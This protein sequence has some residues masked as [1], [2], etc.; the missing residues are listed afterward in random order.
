MDISQQRRLI[1]A[2]FLP[3]RLDL[4]H[5]D[6]FAL[7]PDLGDVTLEVVAG[8]QLNDGEDER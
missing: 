6:A 5:V 1:E 2:I 8:R 7:R 3:E 4:L